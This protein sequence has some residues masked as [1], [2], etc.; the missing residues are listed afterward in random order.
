VVDIQSATAEIRRGKKK[1]EEEEEETAAVKTAM[2][3]GHKY[4]TF[5]KL[6][7]FT[8]CQQLYK[9]NGTRQRVS[10][11]WVTVAASCY[12]SQQQTQLQA[13]VHTRSNTLE[14]TI[15]EHSKK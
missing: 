15:K 13:H 9:Y 8:P 14:T 12:T 10:A 5:S 1:E 4:G 2:Q 11:D 6:Y 7:Q 3:G